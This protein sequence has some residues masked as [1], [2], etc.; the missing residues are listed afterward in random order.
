MVNNSPTRTSKDVYKTRDMN[1]VRVLR[2]VIL[3]SIG[4]GA[5]VAIF[6]LIGLEVGGT[7]WKI[8]GT[9]FSITGAALVAMPSVAAWER[10][11]LGQLPIVGIAAAIL[12]FA[13]VILG[14]WVEPAN[15]TLW[16]LPVTLIIAGVAIAGFSLLEFARLSA[17]QSWILTA[18][19]VMIAVVAL[20]LAVAVWTEVGGD[21]YWRV[22]A[23]ATVLLAASLA[24][25]PVLHKS[26]RSA[27]SF[28]Y[29]P[30]CGSDSP[31]RAGEQT[32]CPTCQSR[33]R[34]SA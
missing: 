10:E 1:F 31:T 28:R 7:G 24:S 26:S 21:G 6:A 2:G 12:G 23:I 20:M 15:D 8:V 34:V 27:Q 11:K 25:V 13:G 29:C 14:I 3:T 18:T 16:K 17:G 5:A 19:R 33:Y 22:F 32:V 4:I 9:S 30:V